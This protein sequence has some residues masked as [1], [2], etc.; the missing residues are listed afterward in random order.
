M[1]IEL[2]V[3]WS[4]RFGDEV[5][6]EDTFGLLTVDVPPALW[7]E[8]LTFARDDL[9]CGYFDWLSAVDELEG[10]FA[11]VAHLYSLAERH[12]LLVRTRVPREDPRLASATG[13][14]RGASWHERETHE[15]FGV[16]F[17]GHPGLEPLLLPDGFEG[18][19]LRKEFVLA[20]RVA[21]PWPG[22]KEPGESGHGAPSRR[23]MLPPG[24]P[25]DWGP[26]ARAA[27]A[28]GSEGPER[29][30]PE[31]PA[32]RRERGISPEGGDSNV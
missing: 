20:A 8:S 32:R 26:A 12:H 6:S 2:S 21:K 13:V 30:R 31:R 7:I 15:M 1:T 25:Q 16:L 17:D 18:H 4:R 3:A 24:V 27:A 29:E 10:G 11:I 9:H 14:Y 22:A 28:E 23:R 5:H 19:P